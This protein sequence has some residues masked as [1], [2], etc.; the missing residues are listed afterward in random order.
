[1]LGLVIIISGG[2]VSLIMVKLL[3]KEL[4]NKERHEAEMKL[5][6]RLFEVNAPPPEANGQVILSKPD[7]P[8]E[9]NNA[10]T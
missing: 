5:F 10:K 9:D 3:K 8:K 1:M 7:K 6:Q 2:L 4:E